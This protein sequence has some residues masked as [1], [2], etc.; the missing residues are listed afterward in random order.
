MTSTLQVQTIQGPTSGS[1]SNTIRVAGGHKLYAQGHVVQV[2]AYHEADVPGH[3][4]TDSDSF[5][6]TGIKNTITPQFSNSL[7]ICDFIV[8]VSTIYEISS[9]ELRT[10]LLLNDVQFGN[11]YTTGYMERSSSGQSKYQPTA[12]KTVHEGLAVGDPVEFKVQ[13]RSSLN[14]ENVMLAHD[15]SSIT[16]TLTEIAQ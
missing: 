14:G 8:S 15:K 7:I 10:R 16:M 12:F 13:F 1:D 6:E 9:S 3:I 4:E 2:Q 11:L 5:Q